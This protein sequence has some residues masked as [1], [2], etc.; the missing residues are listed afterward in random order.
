M[1]GKK[2]V[3]LV[4]DDMIAYEENIKESYIKKSMEFNKIIGYKFI[5][6]NGIETK[7]LMFTMVPPNIKHLGISLT[8]YIKI[9]MPK[10]LMKEIKEEL[11]AESYTMF[12]GRRFNTV[13]MSILSKLICSYHIGICPATLAN[14][15]G[16]FSTH[17][18]LKHASC[19]L[20]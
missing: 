13:N 20:V 14:L 5:I 16:N 11:E 15:N 3:A 12:M 1:K 17:I 9:Y 7:N 6:Q 19:Y 2:K 10:K 8:K 18:T 4:I